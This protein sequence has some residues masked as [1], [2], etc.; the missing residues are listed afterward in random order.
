M[1]ILTIF[2][3][4]F[5]ICTHVRATTF[6][7]SPHGSNTND[8]LS[9]SR[10]FKTLQ[11]A[12][13]QMQSDDEV[14]VL[15]G[16][17]TEQFVLKSNITIKAKNPH[18]VIF[19]GAEVLKGK[20]EKHTDTIYKIKVSGDIKQ[21]FFNN[22]PMTWACYPNINW[23]NNWDENKKWAVATTGTGPGVL[24]SESFKEIAD[25]NL[26]GAYCFLR[27]GKGNSCYSR[28]IKSFD[29]KTL[30][31]DDTDFYTSK[32]T[33]EDGRRGYGDALK[34]LKSTSD[35]HPSK[36]KFFIAGS[37]DLLDAPG[38][39]F[40][41]NGYL[42][43]Y[44]MDNK[45]PEE[46]LLLIKKHD[47]IIQS[48]EEITGV[49]IEGIEFFACSIQLNNVRNSNI[50]FNNV[51]FKYI[52][53]E[54]LYKDR[55]KGA[56]IDKPVFVSGK[57]IQFKHCLFAGAQNSALR[58][59]G[60][61]LTVENCVFMENNHNANFESRALLIENDGVY[62][63]THN[64]FF[65]NCSDAIR[66][67]PSLKKTI[68]QGSE[69][70]YNHIF[71]GG[72][73]NSDC[74]GIYMPTRSQG[75]AT[76]HHNWIHNIHGTAIRL[77]LAG[78]E[79]NVHHN[80]LWASKRGMSIEGYKN[81]N[82]YNNT[83][84]YNRVPSDLN[85]N[86]LNHGKGVTDGSNE[87]NFPPIEDWNVLNNL[88]EKFNDRVG[89]RE[90]ATYKEQQKKGL[91]HP[92]RAKKFTFQVQNRGQIK[93]N[94]IGEHRDYF[95]NGELSNLNLIPINSVIQD[96][97]K[98]SDELSK[99]GVCSLDSFRGAYDVG[100]EYWYPGSDWMPY[101]LEVLNTMSKAENF[102]KKY[103]KISVYQKSEMN[104]LLSQIK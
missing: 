33:G 86:I 98:Q 35:I 49:K 36:S 77:D 23:D 13:D 41:E 103:N 38:E 56:L 101:D 92:E 26:K 6:Y 15:D 50:N 8:G 71:N 2:L 85:R 19:S 104:D 24:T 91:V 42:Y 76:V 75:Y 47:Y 61:N 18:K 43:F 99:D 62:R 40:V 1:K 57:N 12:I 3:V 82:I 64:T 58:L 65:N 10:P 73:Y 89:P 46:S 78:K 59:Q 83:D 80:V 88:V 53:G 16:L 94:I 72:K 34:K 45:K 44:P 9:E 54:L 52:G 93:G 90:K 7:I 48:T 14:I 29:G 81:F 5:C 20:F 4:V 22:T 68:T 74:S 39:W 28:E 55:V 102:A 51:Y 100:S 63:V 32:Y 17:Y 97:E 79:L 30:L 95:T 87:K 60:S 37:L 27:Y 21:L 25:L 66:I 96:G 69:I 70:A 11:F 67:R 84:V 31:W